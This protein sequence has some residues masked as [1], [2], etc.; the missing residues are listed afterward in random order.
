MDKVSMAVL[1]ITGL[2]F[3]LAGVWCVLWLTWR[4]WCECAENHPL[5]YCSRMLAA[6]LPVSVSLTAKQILSWLQERMERAGFQVQTK[7]PFEVLGGGLGL[8]FSHPTRETVSIFVQDQP[9][10]VPGGETAISVELNNSRNELV[11]FRYTVMNN[12]LHHANGGIAARGRALVKRNDWLAF[13]VG[14]VLRLEY[15]DTSDIPA[16]NMIDSDRSGNP[17]L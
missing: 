15:F 5:E 1:T 4:H 10:A 14:D 16:M 7:E 2:V 17:S 12:P 6:G 11:K 13:I 8:V 9:T 3:I